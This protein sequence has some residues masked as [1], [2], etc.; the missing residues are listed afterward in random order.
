VKG[1]VI[2]VYGKSKCR[3][4]NN[5]ND[6]NIIKTY[7]YILRTIIIM[8]IITIKKIIFILNII[9]KKICLII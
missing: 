2:E 3:S 4:N 7:N 9:E 1:I 6:N 5:T 8:I